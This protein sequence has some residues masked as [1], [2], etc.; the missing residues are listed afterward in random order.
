MKFRHSRP[1][2]YARVGMTIPSKLRIENKVI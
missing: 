2:A 1:L